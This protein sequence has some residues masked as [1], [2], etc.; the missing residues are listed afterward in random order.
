MPAIRLIALVPV[1]N[2]ATMLP[3]VV[4]TLRQNGLPCLLV[5]DGSE[6]L[7]A[8]V[9]DQLADEHTIFK[10]RLTPNQGKGAAI[11]A[12]L[13]GAQKIGYTHA[14]QID[15]DGQHDLSMI[16]HFI[17]AARAA[18][19]AV[20][21]GYPNYDASVPKLRLYARYLTHIWV[22][23]N[24]LSFSIPDS[25]CGFRVYPLSSSVSLI[26]SIKIGKR[27]DFDSEILVRMY[28]RNQAMLWL[29]VQ[30]HYP[31]NGQSHFRPWRDNF[32]ISWM[33]TRLFFGMLIRL[34]LL[35]WRKWH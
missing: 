16:P 17:A 33:H 7:C 18:P 32:L 27:M 26:N 29:P 22:W 12:G 14:L 24:T 9:I 2:H 34:P 30:V 5:D 31:Q 28:W 20:I 15:A 1:Y 4:S 13:R 3:K 19:D 10:L 23:I 11:M 6:A 21:C 25:M 8:T 35:I